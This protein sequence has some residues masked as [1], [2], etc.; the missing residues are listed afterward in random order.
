MQIDSPSQPSIGPAAWLERLRAGDIVRLDGGTGS[1]LRRLGV[2]L[3]P[4]I[5]SAQAALECP[6]LLTR[7]HR[8]YIDAGADILTTNTFAATRFVLDAVGLADELPRIVRASVAAAVRA[9]EESGAGRVALAGSI[10]CLP[11][12]FDPAAYPTE[13][14][15][16]AAYLELAESLASAGVDLLALEM[17]EH[18]RHASLAF[19]AAR[20]TG[21]PIVLGLS[22][23]SAR[24]GGLV[25]FDDP[26][27]RFE[28]LLDALLPG[29]PTVVAI[30]HTPPSV[31]ESAL[32][33]LKKDWKGPIGVYP[34]LQSDRLP[35]TPSAFADRACGWAAAGARL[36]G[37][38]CGTTPE[39]VRALLDANGR[40]LDARQSGVPIS[41]RP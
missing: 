11:P 34:E 6:D 12:R 26:T 19:S 22:V 41:S 21:L 31:V 24:D 40:L 29:E 3:D 25:A 8:A 28:T 36:L 37:G 17:M 13:R 2:R 16:R 39:H 30:M 14:R 27:V 33:I 20:E 4:A 23:R 35:L 15:E 7:V 10:S 9:Q 32:E 1:E 38:C 5:W 18:P